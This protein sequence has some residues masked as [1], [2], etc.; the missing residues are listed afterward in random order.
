MK[1][2]RSNSL[3]DRLIQIFGDSTKNH[4]ALERTAPGLAQVGEIR[5]WDMYLTLYQRI[6]HGIGTIRHEPTATADDRPK[7]SNALAVKIN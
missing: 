1:A 5:I 4:Q 6:S 3:F 7:I 2:S